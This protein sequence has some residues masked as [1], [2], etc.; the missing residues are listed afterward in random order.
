MIVLGGFV[1]RAPA[2]VGGSRGAPVKTW[3]EYAAE[4]FAR[5]IH[6]R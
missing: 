4:L 1:G 6:D 3:E 2:S 5:M